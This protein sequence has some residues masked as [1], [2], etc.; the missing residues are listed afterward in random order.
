[1]ATNTFTGGY[2]STS[3]FKSIH[4]GL[5][6]CGMVQ[7]SDTG[8]LSLASAPAANTTASYL[9]GYTVY[10]WNDSYQSTYP[11]FMR[12][13]WRNTS[14]T[15]YQGTKYLAI[16]V[17]EGTDGAGNITG[18]T[19]SFNTFSPNQTTT[20]TAGYISLV[21]GC[22]TIMACVSP[23]Y[24]FMVYTIDRL[25][26]VDGTKANG[27]YGF[28]SIH[29]SAT[30]AFITPSQSAS[31]AFGTAKQF[32]FPYQSW[33]TQSLTAVGSDI[34]FVP[35][36]F[37]DP[38]GRAAL[39]PIAVPTIEVPFDYNFTVNRF[40]TNRTFKSLGAGLTAT[41]IGGTGTANICIA[42]PWE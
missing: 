5:I 6:A 14:S 38:V 9:F 27:V 42:I 15:A 21:D 10:R 16:T 17:G 22:L 40:G 36:T 28:S 1:M 25:R 33:A 2:T 30:E 37:I 13:E 35:K 26:N 4:D 32:Y 24:A 23:T 12:I 8:Q 34:P 39:A 19:I 7:T 20:G 3:I 29:T 31:V 41:A 18:K 11:L